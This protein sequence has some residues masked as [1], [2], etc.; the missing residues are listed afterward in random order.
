MDPILVC[1]PIPNSCTQTLRTFNCVLFHNGFTVYVWSVRCM[2]MFYDFLRSFHFIILLWRQLPLHFL[3]ISMVTTG[4]FHSLSQWILH[5]LLLILVQA[6]I[7]AS[8]RQQVIQNH[9]K[10]SRLAEFLLLY[11]QVSVRN[12]QFLARKMSTFG[13]VKHQRWKWCNLM[14]SFSLALIFQHQES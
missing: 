2:I 14:T 9:M 3:L 4:T 13:E 5:Q 12:V 11:F 7:S 6:V 8:T 10:A 1:M